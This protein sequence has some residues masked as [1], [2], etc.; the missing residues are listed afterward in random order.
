MGNGVTWR[1]FITEYLDDWTTAYGGYPLM[2][3]LKAIR[4][5]WKSGINNGPWNKP[6]TLIHCSI[7]TIPVLFYPCFCLFK[8][9]GREHLSFLIIFGSYL[10]SN[11][12]TSYP[13]RGPWTRQQVHSRWWKIQ[14]GSE[15]ELATFKEYLAV[16][17]GEIISSLTCYTVPGP[18]DISTMLFVLLFCMV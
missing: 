18:S 6:P 4:I 2:R 8:Y 15:S 7:I 5:P 1:C 9:E 10:V 11:Y 17:G 12:I 14:V 13:P 3:A 16:F